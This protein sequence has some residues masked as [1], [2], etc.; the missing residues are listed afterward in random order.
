MHFS[1]PATPVLVSSKHLSLPQRRVNLDASLVS[2]WDQTSV[3]AFQDT[4]GKP[5]VKVSTKGQGP[6]TDAPELS[7]AVQSLQRPLCHTRPAQRFA[8]CKS[9]LQV[10]GVSELDLSLSLF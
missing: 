5:A 2:V 8:G 9:N 3:D 10:K 4:P 7:K 1:V 6:G